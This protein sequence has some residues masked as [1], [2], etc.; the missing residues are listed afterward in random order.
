MKTVTM[1]EIRSYTNNEYSKS[2]SS[3]LRSPVAATKL[4]KRLKKMGIS[5][6]KAPI[7]IA[8]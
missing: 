7:K 2:L 5:A 3:K 8:I 4:V 1:Y 6:F